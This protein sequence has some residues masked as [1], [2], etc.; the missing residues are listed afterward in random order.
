MFGA[1]AGPVLA[2]DLRAQ[3][4]IAAPGWTP[5]DAAQ[6]PDVSRTLAS[7]YAAESKVIVGAD[8]TKAAARDLMNA[9]DVLHVAAPVQI[10]AANPLFSSVLV[11]PGS[12][13]NDTG[14]WALREWFGNPGRTQVLS[15]PDGSGFGGTRVSAAMDALAWAAAAHGI[16]TLAIGRWPADGFAIDSVLTRVH[17]ELANST[18]PAEALR[19]AIASARGTNGDAP[20]AW[21]GLRLIGAFR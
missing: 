2:D 13:S 4:A 12:A 5:P 9:A 14:R 10:N 8:A 20:S 7:L 3:L 17:E 6:G 11:S 18:P 21:G 15:L 19:A 1:L 16:S